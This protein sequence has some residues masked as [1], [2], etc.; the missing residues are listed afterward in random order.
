LPHLERIYAADEALRKGRVSVARDLLVS[1]TT[2]NVSDRVRHEAE[3]R[4]EILS[5]R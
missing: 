3:R 1:I 4:L 2:S 5:R